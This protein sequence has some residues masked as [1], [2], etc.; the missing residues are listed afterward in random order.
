MP[1]GHWRSS[2]GPC[3]P[4][5]A[6]LVPG[7]G[8]GGEEARVGERDEGTSVDIYQPDWKYFNILTIYSCSHNV[9]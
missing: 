3:V 4:G 2:V 5:N 8:G 1:T 6:L 9:S 7:E